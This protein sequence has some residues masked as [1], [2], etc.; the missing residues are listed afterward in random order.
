MNDE[1]ANNPLILA[2]QKQFLQREKSVEN[3]KERDIKSSLIEDLIKV[4]SELG[5]MLTDASGIVDKLVELGWNKSP[6]IPKRRW[7]N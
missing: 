1:L 4:A 3:C 2:R 5:I 7:N 6:V